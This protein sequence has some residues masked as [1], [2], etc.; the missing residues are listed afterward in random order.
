[1]TDAYIR[2]V[3]YYLPEKVLTNNEL[4]SLFPEWTSEKIF[5]KLG[6]ERRHISGDESASDMAV[7]AAEKLFSRNEFI[8]RDDIDLYYSAHKALIINCLRQH[9]S[10]RT[11]L[12][13]RKIA[14]HLI[15]ISAVLDI[16]TVLHSP[17]G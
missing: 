14:V 13:S 9:V 8:K 3:E 17:K 7:K 6:I 12:E 2:A 15:L 5:A 16:F 1:M 4:E 10:F 11:G